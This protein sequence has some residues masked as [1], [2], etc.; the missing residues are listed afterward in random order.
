MV[1]SNGFSALDMH[2]AL[3][4]EEDRNISLFGVVVVVEVVDVRVVQA[5]DVNVA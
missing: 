5:E 2:I 4:D 3:V 1:I